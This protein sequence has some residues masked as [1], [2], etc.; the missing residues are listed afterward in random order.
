VS[1]GKGTP[2][3]CFPFLVIA[4]PRCGP[5]LFLSPPYHRLPATPLRRSP[6]QKSCF[7][8]YDFLSSFQSSRL[9]VDHLLSDLVFFARSPP[10]PCLACRWAETGSSWRASLFRPS[11]VFRRRDVDLSKPLSSFSSLVVVGPHAS[12]LPR[13]RHDPFVSL[14]NFSAL[15]SSIAP[16]PGRPYI[17]F[18]VFLRKKNFPVDP[19]LCT[20]A[21]HPARG[22]VPFPPALSPLAPAGRHHPTNTFVDSDGRSSSFPG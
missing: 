8:D 11:N 1:P 21:A 14:F 15:S 5:D 3:F 13:N 19:L 4:R 16:A 10:P 20:S 7:G 6:T 9:S 2:S 17:T 12:S 18:A 22:P